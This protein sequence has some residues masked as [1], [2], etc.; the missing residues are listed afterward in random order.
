VEF[1]KKDFE[2]KKGSVV[3]KPKQRVYISPYCG[4][5]KKTLRILFVDRRY[6]SLCNWRCWN[7]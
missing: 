1:L 3:P 4:Q 5:K 7:V 6:T 2:S